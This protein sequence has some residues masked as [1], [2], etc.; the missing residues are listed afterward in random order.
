MFVDTPEVVGGLVAT[1]LAD[2]A[3][4]RPGGRAAD[5]IV[6]QFEIDLEHA[7]NSSRRPTVAEAL[8]AFEQFAAG[9][10]KS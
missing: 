3:A 6:A 1:A 8:D 2:R 7:R 4:R 9:A 5:V 10:L